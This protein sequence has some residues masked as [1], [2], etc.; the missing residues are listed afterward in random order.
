MKQIPTSPLI[1]RFSP[2]LDTTLYP[3]AQWLYLPTLLSTRVSQPKQSR[4]FPSVK[5]ILQLWCHFHSPGKMF[6]LPVILQRRCQRRP[7]HKPSPPLPHK[8]GLLL[9]SSLDLAPWHKLVPPPLQ[10]PN[11]PRRNARRSLPRLNRP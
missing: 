11:P 7:P 5:N 6:S 3:K 8:S 9:P 1:S 2:C 4:K 10:Q